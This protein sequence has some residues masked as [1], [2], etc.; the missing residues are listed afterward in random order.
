MDAI[1]RD[2]LRATASALVDHPRGIVA[3]DA[4]SDRPEG[5]DHD[6]LQLVAT[7]PD[8]DDHL[9]GLVLP[10]DALPRHTDDGRSF[11][12]LLDARGLLPG[13][14]ADTGSAS[15]PG[16]PGEVVT[17]GTDG[18]AER[19]AG[20]ERAGIRFVA[21]RSRTAVGNDVPTA[22]ALRSNANVLARYARAAQDAGVVPL[23]HVG[24]VREG[25]HTAEQGAAALATA[26]TRLLVEL[27]DAR[28]DLRAVVLSPATALPGL[29][30]PQRIGP[31]DVARLTLEVLRL[32]LPPE[33]PGVAVH[34][35][36]PDRDTAVAVLAGLQDP[37]APW[38]VTFCFGRS[39]T[40]PAVR[41]WRGRTWLAHRAQVE[42]ARGV[43]RAC[44]VL[45]PS[46]PPLRIA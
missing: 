39:L 42:I 33:L 21:C 29:H 34:G 44:T 26:L 2:T 4:P 6:F 45:R 32:V 13:V 28:V 5:P 19:L 31:G 25:R 7:T 16:S 3:L 37:T 18:L 30:S 12:R 23:L 27:D 8:L 11:P 38:P 35:P 17:A 22:W 10:A 41:A 36:A 9:N 46:R 40:G 20:Y 43:E 24:M 1:A 15:L 14:R